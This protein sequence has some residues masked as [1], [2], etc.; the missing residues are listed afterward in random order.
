MCINY[1]KYLISLFLF[2]PVSLYCVDL[3]WIVPG[4]LWMTNAGGNTCEGKHAWKNIT[5]LEDILLFK[6][7]LVA[8]ETNIVDINFASR[9]L[10]PGGLHT[11]IAWIDP[12]RCIK[13]VG[14]D[15]SYYKLCSYNQPY[16]Y[17]DGHIINNRELN[18][19]GN[20][21][22][23]RFLTEEEKE[24]SAAKGSWSK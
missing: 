5:Q 13:R 11:R 4:A 6:G 10:L 9:F 22:R 18:K 16:S 15:Y 2:F 23:M 7:R 21:L 14:D 24:Q 19:N 3:A 12:E 1:Q 8:Y 17:C 20:Y